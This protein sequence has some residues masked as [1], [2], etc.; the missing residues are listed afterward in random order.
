MDCTTVKPGAECV[1]MTTKGCSFN[2][3]TCHHTVDQCDGCNRSSEFPSGWYCTACPDPALKW[4]GGRC[5]LATH[6]NTT[7]KSDTVK[8][9]PL[10]ASKRS[11]R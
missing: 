11:A 7:A 3:G 9:N 1:F 4:K 2:G 10:K 6:V 5:N 8:V